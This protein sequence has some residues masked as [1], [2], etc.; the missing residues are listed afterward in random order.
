MKKG[1][2]K[3]RNDTRKNGG[4]DNGDSNWLKMSEIKVTALT[5]AG[6][7]LLM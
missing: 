1:H 3:P 2:W 5:T 7:P 6:G 4:S